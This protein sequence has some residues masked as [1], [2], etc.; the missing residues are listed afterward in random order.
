M[1]L[2][3]RIALGL[4]RDRRARL[5]A[6]RGRRVP[7]RPSNQLED[8]I[9]DSLL[10]GARDRAAR[11]AGS[12][13]RRPGG[14]SGS[15]GRRPLPAARRACSPASAAQVVDERRHDHR[16]HRRAVRRCPVDDDD[17]ATATPATSARLRTV[18]VDGDRVPGAHRP[19]GRRRRRCRS[20]GRSRRTRT[21]SRRCG[22]SCSRSSLVGDRRGRAARLAVRPA[23]RPPDRAAARRGRAASPAPRTSTRRSRRPAAARS[24]ASPASFSTMVDALAGVEAP[25]AAAGH[26]RQPRAAHAAH[27]PAHERR[28]ARPRRRARPRPA[29]TARCRASGS[30][31][32][33]LTDLVSELVEL[34]TDRGR[35]RGARAGRAR[36]RSPTTSPSGRGAAPGARSP[37]STDGDAGDGARRGRTW[38]SG[39]SRTWSTTRRS[40]A[41][42]RSTIVVTRQPGR[43]ARPT[44]PGIAP[45]GPAARLRPLLPVRRRRAPSPAPGLGLAIVKQIVERHG[46]TVWATNRDGGGRRRRLRAPG[47]AGRPRPRP[48]SS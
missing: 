18:T 45:D 7:H 35:R 39:R 25:A 29:A 34:A 27:Q 32:N 48:P 4:A 46:G 5:R 47:R 44:G 15:G 22:C 1:S 33:E 9:D 23:A 38:P 41:R 31:S 36:G 19:A 12:A 11:G 2:R 13:G 20:P 30:R 28:A 17:R 3:W 8:S 24:A 16:V 43:G 42:A 21:S 40:T 14:P 26:R 10:A 6:R 37:S